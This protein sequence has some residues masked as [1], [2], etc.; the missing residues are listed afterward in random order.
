[1]NRPN[2]RIA[3]F[4]PSMRGGGAERVMLNLTQGFIDRGKQVDLLLAQAEGPL[5]EKVPQE[6]RLFDLKAPRVRSSF[7][8]VL[9]YF[10]KERPQS[11]LT[12]FDNV[13]LVAL[14][15]RRL[16]GVSSRV[17]VTLHN[18][19]SLNRKRTS[20]ASQ[21]LHSALFR[22]FY[23]W[24]DGVVAVSNGV[25]EDYAK[26]TG[27]PR[28]QFRVIYNPVITPDIFQKAQEPLNH[29]W[30]TPEAAPVIVSVG[31]LSVPK[32]FE[33]LIRA[34]ALVKKNQPARL[35]IL[36][37]GELRK[38]LEGLV[39]HLHI[40]AD[41]DLPGYVDNPFK[42]M[43][44]AAVFVLSSQTEGLPMVLI[45]ALAVGAKV[46]STDCKSGPNEI[47]QGGKFGRLVPVGNVALLA[48]AIEDTL[49]FTHKFTPAD[50]SSYHQNFAVEAYL[51][52]LKGDRCE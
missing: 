10:K 37:D 49:S 47:L 35:I 9:K 26:I 1:M 7:S 32:D 4:L 15:A 28:S 19:P 39:A 42:Y 38:R 31:R 44:G 30:F 14:W 5:I 34:F 36:G 16:A 33:T 13:N 17:V 48:Q 27:L 21:K 45:E 20:T 23:P 18:T 29:P 52:V 46:I 50:L 11:M 3:L 40:D 25:A 24:A 51:K 22:C 41:V 12:A 6:V 8:G 43:A 2:E